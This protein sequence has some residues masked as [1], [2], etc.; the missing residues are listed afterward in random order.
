MVTQIILMVLFLGV[1]AFFVFRSK[2]IAQGKATAMDF[3]PGL[4]ALRA[5]F[6]TS[7]EPGETEPVCV[8]A[9]HYSGLSAQPVIVGVTDRHVFV[10]KGSNPMQT[11]PY[12]HEGEHLG[13]TEKAKQKRGFFRW[14]HGD[15]D[16]GSKGYSPKV[17]SGPFAG[18]EWRMY[19]TIEGY[20]QQK[21]SLREFADRFYF[22]WFYD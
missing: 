17:V 4:D 9:Y 8:V 1:V 7:R 5:G 11:F 12:D 14:S 22:Q 15:F 20:P 13:Q 16:D 3:R 2:G 21:S 18:E 6:Q 10:V 19:P